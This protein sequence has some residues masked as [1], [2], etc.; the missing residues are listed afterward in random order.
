MEKAKRNERIAVMAHALITSP[1]QIVNY[2]RFC[3]LFG[4]AKSTI[5]ED[6]SILE[7]TLHKYGLGE[8]STVAGAAGGVRYRP[9]LARKQALTFVTALAQSLSTKERVLPGGFLYLSDVLS[10]PA[11]CRQMGTILAG[12]FYDAGADFV[13]TMETKGIPVALTTAE[14]LNVPLIIA[15]RANKIYEGSSVSIAFP[16]GNGG[17]ENM[18]LSRRAVRTGQKALIIDDFIQKG[19]TASGMVALMQEFDVEVVGMGFVLSRDHQDK[20]LV[21]DIKA[22]MT[23]SMDDEDEQPVVK[24]ASWLSE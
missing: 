13:L 10:D 20:R 21:S 15:R 16:T 18:S 24:P 9:I 17:T 8:L 6:V 1:N 2:G 22:L 5:S 12:E 23:F 19:G 11:L 7:E 4:A 14:A 3:D